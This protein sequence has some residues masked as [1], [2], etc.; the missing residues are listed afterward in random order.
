MKSMEKVSNK[1]FLGY[2]K[3]GSL[4]WRSGRNLKS[5]HQPKHH[6]EYAS[7]QHSVQPRSVVN[8]SYNKT[9]KIIVKKS[10][11]LPEKGLAISVIENNIVDR[12]DFTAE[13]NEK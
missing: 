13:M 1:G 11:S 5:V 6:T 2:A 4:K 12:E 3:P 10:E 8:T 7:I 9:R